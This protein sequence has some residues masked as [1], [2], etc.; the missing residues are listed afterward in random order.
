MATQ[1]PTVA[2]YTL[3]SWDPPKKEEVVPTAPAPDDGEDK[4]EH[5]LKS[6]CEH[7]PHTS[8][9]AGHDPSSGVKPPRGAKYTLLKLS[10]ADLEDK[11][12]QCP[13]WTTEFQASIGKAQDALNKGMKLPKGGVICKSIN[14]S[15]RAGHDVFFYMAT[16][17]HDN[18][19]MKEE[20]VPTAPAP[21]DDGEDKGE[22]GL[23]SRGEHRPHTSAEAG[24]DPNS[25]AK[26][27]IA[28]SKTL[29]RP[30]STNIHTIVGSKMEVR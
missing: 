23:K 20:V 14:Q 11:R 26:P 29:P 13:D 4:G 2:K 12:E 18:A 10:D 8:A 9:E 24:H 22:H 21:D 27:P 17:A 30:F 5:G 1:Q 28:S 15:K 25:G 19:P 3:P 6:L 7:R 16:G